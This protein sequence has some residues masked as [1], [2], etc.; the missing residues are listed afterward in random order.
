MLNLKVD[1]RKRKDVNALKIG[2]PALILIAFLMWIF[3]PIIGSI[4]QAFAVNPKLIFVAIAS[5]LATTL[6]ERYLKAKNTS[7][8]IVMFASLGLGLSILIIGVVL[9]AIPA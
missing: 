1:G 8:Q 7:K 4:G 2:V 6:F 9:T 3:L 5:G